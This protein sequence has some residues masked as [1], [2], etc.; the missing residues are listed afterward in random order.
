[1][2][3][4]GLCQGT[5]RHEIKEC[6]FCGTHHRFRKEDC[7]AY[8]KTCLKCNRKNHFQRK[9][10]LVGA[11]VNAATNSKGSHLRV[12]QVDD[13]TLSLDEE[14]LNT[15]D[16]GGRDLKCC[17][18]VGGKEIT[19]Q[20]D[21]GS[22]VNMLPARLTEKIEP[23]DNVLKMWNHTPLSPLRKSKQSVLNSKNGKEYIL[24]FIVFKENFAP[25]LGLR[26]SEQMNLINVYTQNFDSIAQLVSSNVE[27]NYPDVFD[28][29][30]GTLPGIQHLEVDPNLKPVVM[31]NRTIPISLRPELKTELEK[32]VDKGVITPVNEPTPRVSQFFEIDFL[33]ET[34]SEAVVT[35]MKYHFAHRGISDVVVSDNA[36]QYASQHFRSFAKK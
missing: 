7:P 22:S 31:A 1:M 9:C 18:L 34:T 28:D 15:V 21:T 6:K 24:D 2:Y 29:S 35:K 33:P 3:K 4:V 10:I 17:M 13:G 5:E 8:G 25:R 30:L 20:I 14:W 16:S 12:H 11:S 27:D 19:F 26:A 23:T 32:R 36:P